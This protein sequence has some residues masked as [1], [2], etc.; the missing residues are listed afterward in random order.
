MESVI[1]MKKNIILPLLIAVL[2]IVA[3]LGS[4]SR[5]NIPA[6][7]REQGQA[8]QGQE[9][10]ST[11]EPQ[12]EAEADLDLAPKAKEEPD[13]APEIQQEAGQEPTQEPDPALEAKPNQEQAP[14]AGQSPETDPEAEQWQDLEAT[15][16]QK[17]LAPLTMR[18]H[19]PEYFTEERLALLEESGISEY[20]WAV[21]TEFLS[22]FTTIFFEKPIH[23][24]DISEENPPNIYWVSYKN[25]NN[26]IVGDF[27]DRDGNKIENEPW[28]GHSGYAYEYSLHHLDNSGIPMIFVDKNVLWDNYH[29]IT[30]Y[31]AYRYADGSYREVRGTF[32]DI[33]VGLFNDPDGN[34]VIHYFDMFGYQ[35]LCYATFNNDVMETKP[36]ASL[37]LGDWGEAGEARSPAV[38]TNHITGETD[39]PDTS[40]MW[41]LGEPVVIPGTDTPLTRIARLS[42]LENDMTSIIKSTRESV[43]D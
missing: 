15:N 32:W 29:D 8:Q 21:A 11:H 35:D 19:A 20:G 30:D 9:A 36:L 13:T 39:I 4:C 40:N 6:S 42:D 1:T 12:G 41:F 43:L 34:F 2:A 25:E 16:E 26:I 31:T 17:P 14:E 5:G 10:D 37:I 3:M 28:L 23:Y 33:V 24:Q 7:S 18:Y 22:Q 27:F 38:W